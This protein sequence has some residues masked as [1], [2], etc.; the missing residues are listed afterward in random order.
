[1][2]IIRRRSASPPPEDVPRKRPR[3][4]RSP[5]QSA[6]LERSEPRKRRR[7]AGKLASIMNMPVDVFCEVS[8]DELGRLVCL[9]LPLDRKQLIARRPSEDSESFEGLKEL[10]DVQILER[11]LDCS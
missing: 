4:K 2:L 10:A 11:D 5:E 9:Y 7:I 3:T 6:A 1:M 8:C